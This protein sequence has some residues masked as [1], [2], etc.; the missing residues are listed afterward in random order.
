MS[1]VRASAKPNPKHFMQFYTLRSC[2]RF[3]ILREQE[4]FIHIA[5]EQGYVYKPTTCERQVAIAQHAQCDKFRLASVSLSSAQ[6]KR[7]WLASSFPSARDQCLDAAGAGGWRRLVENTHRVS[8]ALTKIAHPLMRRTSSVQSSSI[9]GY[10]VLISYS[11]HQPQSPIHL[12]SQLY[13]PRRPQQF[14]PIIL[15]R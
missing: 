11:L 15:P 6:G 12:H 7:P 3:A 14:S 10:V 13:P 9:G 2:M 5:N 1:L 4:L 8:P